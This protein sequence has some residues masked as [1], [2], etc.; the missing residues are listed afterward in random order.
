MGN[1]TAHRVFPTYRLP[2]VEA[3]FRQWMTE[4]TGL[5]GDQ[6]EQWL[7]DRA[8]ETMTDMAADEHP[9]LTLRTREV[10]L[11]AATGL[12]RNEIA[13]R[14]YVSPETVKE[15]VK[16]AMRQTGCPNITSLVVYALATGQLAGVDHERQA[17]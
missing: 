9:V 17:A 5:E 16:I 8:R 7:V 2:Q 6:L 10:L 4:L 15:N 3:R 12:T 13:G 1:T 11:L 14:L